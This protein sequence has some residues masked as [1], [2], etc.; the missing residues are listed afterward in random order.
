MRGQLPVR[1]GRGY[2]SRSLNGL[3]LFVVHYSAG[4]ARVGVRAVAGYQ[5]GA[6]SHLPFPAIAYHWFVEGDGTLYRCHDYTV[7]TWG[8]GGAGVNERA[9]HCCYAGDVEPN[10]AQITGMRRARELTE[11]E[12][13][14]ELRVEG[15]KDRD[16]TRC[17]VGW[18]A[19]ADKLR[20]VE[21]P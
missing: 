6:S 2:P 8:S 15:H 10:A 21:L 16:A 17:P 20:G 3:A 9:V 7:R 5:T 12:L 13:G 11:A 4:P 14:W 1:P 19:W 18:P